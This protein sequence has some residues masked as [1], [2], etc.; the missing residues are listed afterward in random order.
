MKT[1]KVICK[2]RNSKDYI[3]FIKA[4]SM[5]NAYSDG[6]RYMLLKKS[7]LDFIEVKSATK[8]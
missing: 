2:I 3:L 5:E 6:K 4:N 7:N 1:Y 8:T